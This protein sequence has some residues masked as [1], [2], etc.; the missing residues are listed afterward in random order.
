M[1][2]SRSPFALLL[3]VTLLAAPAAAQKLTPQ[4]LQRLRQQR[5]AQQKAAQQRAAQQRAAQRNAVL[6]ARQWYG[7][8]QARPKTSATPFSGLYGQQFQGRAFGRPAAHYAQRPIVVI[9]R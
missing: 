4:Q 8:S 7:Y 1:T 9:S 6:A 5:A 2:R 3:V